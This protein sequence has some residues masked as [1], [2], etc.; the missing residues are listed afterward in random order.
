LIIKETVI[1]EDIPQEKQEVVKKILDA[2]FSWSSK[3]TEIN[4]I[5]GLCCICR[6]IPTK[7]I[8]HRLEDEDG[9]IIR[10]ERY[11]DSCFQKR[12]LESEY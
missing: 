8:K 10:A 9:V 2:K 12:N 4:E 3:H 5:T 11:C 1:I 7:I 6:E